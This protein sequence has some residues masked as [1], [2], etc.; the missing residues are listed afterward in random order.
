C[1][2]PSNCSTDR[3]TVLLF[4]GRTL[5]TGILTLSR[6]RSSRCPTLII[7]WLIGRGIGLGAL[8]MLS[9][10]SLGI[11]VRRLLAVRW[12]LAIS[13]VLRVSTL[14]RLIAGWIR[15]LGCLALLSVGRIALL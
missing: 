5:L 11:A 3:P 2:T 13:W 14:R 10:L 6:V 9:V 7:W 12:L 15:R 1:Y 8:L 4:A